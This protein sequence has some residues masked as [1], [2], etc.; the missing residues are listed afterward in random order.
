MSS[1]LFF[2]FFFKKKGNIP[3]GKPQCERAGT[4][5]L[6]VYKPQEVECH[7]FHSLG[8]VSF[9]ETSKEVGVIY[10]MIEHEVRGMCKLNILTSGPNSIAA[11]VISVRIGC[12]FPDSVT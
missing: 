12:W 8:G 10:P 9:Y 7:F 2:F 4:N 6:H 11:S 5:L 3:L 1:D